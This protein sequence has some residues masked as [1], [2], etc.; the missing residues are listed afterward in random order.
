MRRWGGGGALRTKV[1]V[2]G[3]CSTQGRFPLVV[4]LARG[5]EDP[6]CGEGEEDRMTCS[7]RCLCV[8]LVYLLRLADVFHVVGG[9]AFPRRS[10]S[11]LS[12]PL[13]RPQFPQ[14]FIY[15]WTARDIDPVSRGLCNQPFTS[16]PPTHQ[17]S[18]CRVA[19]PLTTNAVPSVWQTNYFMTR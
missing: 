10:P 15:F 18:C 7:L 6:V 12:S 9:G 11:R 4:R 1:I 13:L 17:M 2:R 5:Y 16:S 8:D 3:I 14:Q 19:H